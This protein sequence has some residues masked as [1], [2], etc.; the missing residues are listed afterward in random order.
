[1]ASKS[2]TGATPMIIKKLDS[3]SINENFDVTVRGLHADCQGKPMTCSDVV[4][5]L[6]EAV[7]EKVKTDL[8]KEFVFG[9]DFTFNGAKGQPPKGFQS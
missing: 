4:I 1:M 9:D 7:I 8:E 6:L 5:A 3:I 2:T